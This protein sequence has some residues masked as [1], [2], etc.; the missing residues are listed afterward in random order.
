ML[1]LRGVAS[2]II[3][4][5]LDPFSICACAYSLICILQIDDTADVMTA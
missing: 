4:S 3:G 5:K 2:T 1:A